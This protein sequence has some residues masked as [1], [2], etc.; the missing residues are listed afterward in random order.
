MTALLAKARQL[1]SHFDIQLAMI[2]NFQL[3]H[4]ASKKN[5]RQL[6]I[7]EISADL[8]QLAREL[9]IP[10]IVVAQLSHQPDTGNRAVEGGRPRLN[11]LWEIG[12]LEQDAD[13]VGLLVRP[14]Y[15]EP[16]YYE[17]VGE[18]ELVIT[19]QRNGPTGGVPLVFL[20]EFGRFETRARESQDA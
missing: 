3:L 16:D 6:E 5:N 4:S 12:S 13:I 19:K 14:Q 17:R 2:D 1:K 20:A 18:A 9:S 7:S 15:Y 10:V 11:D 8:K